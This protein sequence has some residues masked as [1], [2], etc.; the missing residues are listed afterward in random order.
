MSKLQEP[1]TYRQAVRQQ[2]W[3]DAMNNELKALEDNQTWELTDLPT[4]KKAIGSKWV[5]KIKSKANGSVDRYNRT[6]PDY[7]PKVTIK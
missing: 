2:E 7:W 6:R 5:Y 1:Y 4:G 3:V